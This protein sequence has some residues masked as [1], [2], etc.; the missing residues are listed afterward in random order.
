MLDVI[1]MRPSQEFGP[2]IL[3]T[4]ARET[5]DSWHR[6]LV[7]SAGF[8]KDEEQE[9]TDWLDWAQLSAIDWHMS[10]S[11]VLVAS[12]AVGVVMSFER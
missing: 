10:R 9:V 3:Q 12:G 5:M 1:A 2:S 8:E 6:Q 4:E 7:I 11:I